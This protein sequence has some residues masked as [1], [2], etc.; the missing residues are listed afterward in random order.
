MLK[1][2][3]ALSYKRVKGYELTS[4]LSPSSMAAY[5]TC[6]LQFRLGKVDRVEYIGKPA[7]HFNFGSAIHKGL[8]PHW[9]GHDENFKD[10]WAEYKTVPMQFKR[11]ET[12]LTMY[13]RGQQMTKEVV[14]ATLGTFEA[15]HSVVEIA[16]NLDLGFIIIK[17]RIDV[18]TIAKRMPILISGQLEDFSGP[19]LLDLKTSAQLYYPDSVYQSQQ[20]MTYSIPSPNLP[21]KP[22][23]A[24]YVVVTKAAKP[25]VQIIGRRY[26]K[27]ELKAQ[28]V[29]YKQVA[30]M[31][32]TGIYVQNKGKHCHF[33]QFRPL[34]YEEKGWQS[35]YK[36]NL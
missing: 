18:L 35:A 13:A 16:E 27:A 15:D 34:C 6:G 3:P 22:A 20:L 4:G 14:E 17:R 9:Q 24:A 11:N 28:I 23:L 8:E 2:N 36:Q 33:C 31:I 1:I 25:S 29:R 26:E 7:A 12:W 10:A 32:K 21:I 5:L 19:I 30:E